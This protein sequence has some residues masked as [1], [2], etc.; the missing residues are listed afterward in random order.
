MSGNGEQIRSR[1]TRKKFDIGKNIVCRERI[2]DWGLVD[3]GM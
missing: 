3:E 1:G 2:W